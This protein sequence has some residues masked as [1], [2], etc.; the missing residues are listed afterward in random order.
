MLKFKECFRKWNFTSLMSIL[1]FL[2]K[3]YATSDHF[4]SKPDN[5]FF[6]FIALLANICFKER[7]GIILNAT[8]F[9]ILL[10]F[11][12]NPR[13]IVN[14]SQKL[15]MKNL[16][17]SGEFISEV[18]TPYQHILLGALPSQMVVLSN[19]EII[20]SIPEVVDADK[21]SALFVSGANLP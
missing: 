8:L 7:V 9:T 1:D 12:V 4:L 10:I 13:K 11:T 18:Y 19:G 17:P 14:F 16:L 20:N 6:Y 5:H 3:Y 15:R 21:D 2:H